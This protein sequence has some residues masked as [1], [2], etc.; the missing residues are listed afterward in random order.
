MEYVDIQQASVIVGKSAKTIRRAIA[1]GKL[2]NY[3]THPN[4]S[5][6][7]TSELDEYITSRQIAKTETRV[8][9]HRQTDRERITELENSVSSLQE[10]M[11]DYERLQERV[12]ELEK[13]ILLLSPAQGQQVQ[14]PGQV[15]TPAQENAVAPVPTKRRRTKQQEP[16]IE[17]ADFSKYWQDEYKSTAIDRDVKALVVLKPSLGNGPRDY[18][19]AYCDWEPTSV[20]RVIKDEMRAR[21]EL[22]RDS[23]LTAVH[24]ALVQHGWI[25]VDVRHTYRLPDA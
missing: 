23:L 4:R 2:K 6:I 22:L 3:S 9:V 17:L 24:N 19:I 15:I 5:K 20:K 16:T 10:R 12:Q 18:H 8:H 13:V 7:A 1:I 11:E 14:S 21:G 25:V